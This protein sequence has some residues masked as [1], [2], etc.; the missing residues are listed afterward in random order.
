MAQ[1]DVHA[2]TGRNTA[3]TPYVVVIQSARY[4]QRPTRV[5]VPLITLPA[6]N[7]GDRTLMP[8]FEVEGKTVFLNPLRALTVPTRALGRKVASLAHDNTSTTII[9]AIDAMMTRA[10]G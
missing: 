6:D 10:Y 3:G 5:V 4:D 8:A 7:A 2:T 9:A 1:F